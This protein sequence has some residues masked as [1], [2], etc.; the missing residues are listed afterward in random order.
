MRLWMRDDEVAGSLM[1]MRGKVGVCDDEVDGR[2]W[3]FVW[4]L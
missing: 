1:T 4:H 2:R 3:P